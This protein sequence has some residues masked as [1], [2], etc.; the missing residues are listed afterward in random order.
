M[1]DE[2][3]VLPCREMNRKAPSM[4]GGLIALRKVIRRVPAS[5]AR[6]S[7]KSDWAPSTRT[8]QLSNLTLR[9][10]FVPGTLRDECALLT[11]TDLDGELGRLSMGSRWLAA[12]KVRPGPIHFEADSLKP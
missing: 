7:R 6:S 8:V 4:L 9:H 1:S 11:S 12:L 2:D 10:K 5:G 3:S